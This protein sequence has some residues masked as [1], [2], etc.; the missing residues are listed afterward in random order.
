MDLQ[1][2]EYQRLVKDSQQ[3]RGQYAYKLTEIID[4]LENAMSKNV[5]QI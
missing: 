4:A 3:F 5:E 1:L 2:S